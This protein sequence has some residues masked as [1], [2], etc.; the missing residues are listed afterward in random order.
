MN[1]TIQTPESADAL[2]GQILQQYDDLSRRLQQIGRYVLDHPSDVALET[3]AVIASRCDVQP[4]AIV[5]FA[6][7]FGFDGAT[8]MQR[9]FRNELV[10]GQAAP[11]YVERVR[12]LKAATDTPVHAGLGSLLAEFVEGSTLGLNGLAHSVSQEALDQAVRLICEARTVHVLGVRRSFPVSSYIAYSLLQAG[13]RAVLVDGAGGLTLHQ[14]RTLTA[15]DVVIAT[16]F[17]PYAEETVA[18]VDVAARQGARIIAISDS[19]VSPIAKPAEVVLQVREPEV[20]G[21]RPLAGSMCLAQTLVIAVAIATPGQ[22][23]PGIL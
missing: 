20:R 7:V 2:R 10:E 16:S 4:S 9:L 21:F 17:Q 5:R 3:L 23:T 15:H 18:A 11:G 12:R 6:K 1:D 19:L 14:M 13:K 22:E 8:Q